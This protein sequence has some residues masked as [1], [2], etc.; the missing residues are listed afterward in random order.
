METTLLVINGI[1]V[2]AVIYQGLQIKKL[3]KQTIEAFS[4][5]CLKIFA[6]NDKNKNNNEKL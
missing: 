4:R 1:L 3:R 2:W 6:V 5:V